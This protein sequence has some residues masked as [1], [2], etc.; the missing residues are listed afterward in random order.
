[1]SEALES[2]ASGSSVSWTNP[3]SGHSGSV[4]PLRTFKSQQGQWCR[5]YTTV[6]MSEAGPRDQRAIAC[7]EGDGVWKT[8]A[9]LVEEI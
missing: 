2:R 4:T 7:R 5:E 6:E 1:M 9:M 3:D 8:R